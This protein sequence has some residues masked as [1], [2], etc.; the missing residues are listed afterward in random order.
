MPPSRL[1]CARK[2]QVRREA[3]QDSRVERDGE[4]RSK[5]NPFALDWFFALE[6]EQ[7]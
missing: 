1:G 4:P 3:S 2:D 6:H 7:I 5:L